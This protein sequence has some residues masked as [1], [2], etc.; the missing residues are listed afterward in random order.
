[1][2]CL[3]YWST[4]PEIGVYG[5]VRKGAF[6]RKV[7]GIWGVVPFLIIRHC[8]NCG[9]CINPSITWS[10]Y[11]DSKNRQMYVLFVFEFD[12]S[13][14]C[15]C[16]CVRLSI[17]GSESAYWCY[18]I[19][20]SSSWKVSVKKIILCQQTEINCESQTEYLLYFINLHSFKM[21]LITDFLC[22][23]K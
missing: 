22:F 5:R 19:A 16:V 9:L 14:V 20:G 15:V 21:S 17:S 23:Y 8:F 2:L 1:M 10:V 13:N 12:E 4:I 3:R 18:L 11:G 7:C 6:E